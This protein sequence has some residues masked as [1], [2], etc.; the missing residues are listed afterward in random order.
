MIVTS[1]HHNTYTSI[2]LQ[3]ARIQANHCLTTCKSLTK[4]S[5]TWL[6]E[7]KMGGL[8]A[9]KTS[10]V[11]VLF[12]HISTLYPPLREKLPNVLYGGRIEALFTDLSIYC[13]VRHS[14]H[15]ARA[16]IPTSTPYEGWVCFWFSP[17][18]WEDSL[19]F[20]GFSFFSKTNT[21]KFPFDVECTGTFKRVRCFVG[22]EIY[23]L[24]LQD[25]VRVL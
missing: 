17:L 10:F 25:K 4:A 2:L 23:K 11:K 22:K 19:G 21:S 12:F 20:F 15:L 7:S 5:K 16:Q 14:H 1:V 18:L 8:L 13:I 9:Q 6:W 24:Q 3:W